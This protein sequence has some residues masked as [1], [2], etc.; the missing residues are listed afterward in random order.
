MHEYRDEELASALSE[1]PVPATSDDFF[2]R[3][4]ARVVETD[5]RPRHA[6]R[7]RLFATAALVG[8]ALVVGG[9]AGATLAGSSPATPSTPVPAFAPAVGWNTV[10]T[11][12]HRS[13]PNKLDLAW[14]ANVPFEP[15]DAQTDWPN[16][17]L[18]DLP[19]DGIVIVVV[20]PW[21]YTGSEQLPDLKL[22]VRLTDLYFNGDNWEGQPAP[23][24][25]RYQIAAHINAQKIVNVY[26]WMG[27]VDPTP[28]MKTA[29]EEEL[30][31]LTLPS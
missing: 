27:R 5:T 12:N 30:A 1:L 11:N 28:A 15:Q 29:A 19:P 8:L 31:R 3:L 17:T 14:A 26:V 6:A 2:G 21:T 4:R 24:V 13:A 25:S 20:G 23:N 10:E 7:R 22:P 16:A 18:R 9:V